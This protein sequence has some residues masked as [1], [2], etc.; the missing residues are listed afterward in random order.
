MSSETPS[1][2]RRFLLFLRD[3]KA[4]RLGL[5]GALFFLFLAAET[6]SFQRLDA[7]RRV[8]DT[9]AFLRAAEAPLLS[10]DFFSTKPIAT[11]LLFKAAGGD[12]RTIVRLQSGLSVLCWLGLAA[13]V[14]AQLRRPLARL[15]A[16]IS[17]CVFSLLRL[18]NQWDAILLSESLAFSLL[19]LCLA[20]TIALGRSLV[21]RSSSRVPLAVLWTAACGLLAVTRDSNL[22]LLATAWG[23]FVLWLVVDTARRSARGGSPRLRRDLLLPVLLLA[24]VLIA[25][26]LVLRASSRWHDPLINVVLQRIVRH[27][28]IYEGWVARYGMPRNAVF[29]A[30]AG[31][32]AW[33][34]SDAGPPIRERF[35]D[36]DPEVEDVRIWLMERGM[37]SYTRYLVWDHPRESLTTSLRAFARYVSSRD[38]LG[39]YGKGV[40]TTPFT[41][42]LTNRVYRGSERPLSVWVG[43]LA[44]AAAFALLFPA[45]RLLSLVSLF[46]IASAWAQAFVTFHGDV[47]NV[48]RHMVVCGVLVRL[49]ALLLALVS[50]D[51]LLALPRW[52]MDRVSRGR[53]AGQ[54]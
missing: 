16:G 52:L 53:R 45:A 13:V 4:V 44:A 32:R 48:D 34:R 21:D 31:K 26:H 33:Q 10:K 37:A 29:E 28:E 35:W 8:P 30:Y 50:L 43:L 19:A 18:V 54:Y 25:G 9:N 42:A 39:Q 36:R 17:I 2:S 15:A 20:S 14:A 1:K 5:W 40:G 49:G 7:P 38:T 12:D 23:V 47:S 51:Q 6:A 22:Y 24:P 27:P 41:I 11:P 3:M 46:L